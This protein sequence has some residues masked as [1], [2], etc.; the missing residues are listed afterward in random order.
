V[1][2]VLASVALLVLFARAGASVAARATVEDLAELSRMVAEGV[3]TDHATSLDRAAGAVWTTYRVRV[4]RMLAGDPAK[5]IAVRIRGGKVGTVEQELIGSP[6]LEDGER[7]VLFLGPEVGGAHEVIGLAQGAFGV[8]TDP[9]TG[10]TFCRNSVEGLT[11]VGR[12]GTESPPEPL[13]L[14]LA[15]LTA[16]VAGALDRLEA[17][18]RAAREALDRRLAAWRRAAERHMEMT[19]GKPGGAAD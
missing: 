19:R 9:K 12:D 6:K 3:V 13:K 16:R 8:E 11:L 17:R 1:R 15:D 18:R 4:G 14:S 10:E 7:V 5:E 2:R